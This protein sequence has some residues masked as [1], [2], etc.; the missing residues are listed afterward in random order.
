MAASTKCVEQFGDLATLEQEN[1][2]AQESHEAFLEQ[3]QELIEQH[4]NRWVAFHDGKLVCT[5]LNLETVLAETDK[6]RIPRST[7]VLEYLDPQPRVM[8]L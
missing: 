3:F 5:G 6:R 8:V 4:P 7:L 1:R 2:M